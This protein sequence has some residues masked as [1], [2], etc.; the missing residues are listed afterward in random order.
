M[1]LRRTAFPTMRPAI[2]NPRRGT[3]A[4][5]FRANIAKQG[6]GRAARVTI[7]AIEFGFLP[8]ALRGFER[9]CG[10]Q[11]QATISASESAAQRIARSGSDRETLATFRAA[12]GEN[13]T[14]RSRGHAGAKAVSA[15]TMQIARLVSTLHAGSRAGK[16]SRKIA[17]KQAHAGAER[18]AARV[19]SASLSVKREAAFRAA[20][21]R[22]KI[23]ARGLWITLGPSV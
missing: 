1:R 11:A 7:H 10:R 3:V 12:P 22:Q 23:R 16:L 20:I 18:R 19:R 2:A 13:L 6:V 4:P 21:D 8:E 14:T 5:V 17:L 15:L 9:P